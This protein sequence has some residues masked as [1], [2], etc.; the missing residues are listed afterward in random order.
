MDAVVTRRRACILVA[1]LALV[2]GSCAHSSS[3]DP[4]VGGALPTTPPG[5]AATST[6]GGATDT[7]RRAADGGKPS[8]SSLNT[9]VAKPNAIRD[10]AGGGPGDLAGVLLA[11]GAATSIVLDVLVQPGETANADVI[12]TLRQILAASSGKPVTVRGPNALN[13]SSNTYDADAVRHLADTQGKDQSDDTVV[14]HLLYLKGAFSDD[15]VLGVTVRADTTAIFPD[16]IAQAASPFA[17]RSRIEQAVDTHELGHIMGLVDIWLNDN[18]D[19]PDH[20]G[21]STNPHS[22]MYWAVESDLVSQVL[23]GPPPVSFDAAD[24]NDLQ[25]IHAGVAPASR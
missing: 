2:C 14:I 20:P 23:D 12:A 1:A 21:H 22:V 6:T 9:T 8:A 7:T 4:S 24:Q 3:D 25:R 19:D 15:S 17:G 11:P 5:Q 16:Q 13:T 18:R 10:A